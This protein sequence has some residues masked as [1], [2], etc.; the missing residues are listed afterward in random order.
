MVREDVY[1]IVIPLSIGLSTCTL[2]A[3]SKAEAVVAPP[4][5]RGL[6]FQRRGVSSGLPAR[7]GGYTPCRPRRPV[8]KV[9]N[10]QWNAVGNKRPY[11]FPKIIEQVKATRLGSAAGVLMRL[12]WPA[13]FVPLA[14]ALD[15]TGAE[16][17]P[18][19]EPALCTA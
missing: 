4:S 12:V 17:P 14:M 10:L 11:L 9:V 16:S 7:L 13:T 6:E 2:S 5:A 18:I 19:E 1:A 15:V 8:C 3:C